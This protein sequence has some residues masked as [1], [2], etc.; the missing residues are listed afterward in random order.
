MKN[1]SNTP[2]RADLHFHSTLSDGSKTPIEIVATAMGRDIEL[3]V[4][5]DHDIVNTRTPELAKEAGIMSFEG[6]EISAYEPSSDK[7][8]HITCYAQKFSGRIH[9]ILTH[10][11]D[12]RKGKITRQLERLR[13]NGFDID[14]DRFFQRF[15]SQGVN[16]DNLSNSHLTEYIFESPENVAHI[17]HLTGEKLEYSMFLRECLKK[18]GK[19]AWIGGVE[20]PVYEP[21]VESCGELARE[22]SALL[23][24]AHPNFTFEDDIDRFD[25]IIMPYIEAGVRGIEINAAAPRM[26]VETILRV[27]D[28]YDLILTFGS[29]CHFKPSG[30]GKHN[31]LGSRNPYL[32]DEQYG[33]MVERFMETVRR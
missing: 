7:H 24:I 22:N 28:R 3:L 30:D 8:L 15:G 2:V 32:S 11:R 33:S 21:S 1:S 20:V 10:T 5:T 17:E 16:T 13:E 25:K 31:E 9:E 12:G 18:E 6:V 23:S 19:H 26:W 14:T 4:N 27:R 29:D